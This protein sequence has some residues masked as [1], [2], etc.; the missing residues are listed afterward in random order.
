VG[1]LVDVSIKYGN[2]I[3]QKRIG[4]ILDQLKVS[5]RIISPL[6]KKVSDTSFLTPLNPKNRKSSVNKKWNVIENVKLS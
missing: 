3:S 6:Q 1:K 4:W 2:T 5:K